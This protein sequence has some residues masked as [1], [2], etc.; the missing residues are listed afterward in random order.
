MI[1]ISKP[2]FGIEEENAVLEVLRSG[3]IV[4]GKKVEELEEKFA[5]V[6]GTKYAVAV[7]SGTAALQISLSAAGIKQGDEIITTPFSFIA[8]ANSCL[9]V[10]ATPVF[11]D[12]NPQTFNINPDLVEAAI[13]KKTRA[14]L[15]VHLFGLPAE[16]KKIQR[17]AKKHRLIIIEDAC[18]AHGASIAGKKVG[19]FGL[20][21]CFS[22]YATKNIAA[23]EGGIITTNNKLFADKC[24][25]LRSHGSKVKY[26]HDILGYN[27]RMTDIEAAIALEQ[28]KKLESNNRKRAD[29]AGFYNDNLHVPGIVQPKHPRGISHVFHQY[30]I[31]ITRACPFTRENLTEELQKNAIGF[32]I[33]YP[34]SIPKQK[35]YQ[36]IGIGKRYKNTL[37]VTERVCKEVISLP[38]HPL[39]TEDDLKKIVEVINH[40]GEKRDL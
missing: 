17:I 39:L 23:G 15:P 29:N 34:L 13:T 19:S 20:A 26:Y 12:I 4:Q 11:V 8:T 38:V 31:Q 5:H 33:F 10:G 3:F 7:S 32:G 40:L 2:D 36:K 14:I 35:L 6:I 30:T 22:F 16:M 27:L 37:P 21:G 28:L 25:L 18:Q 9:Y 24:R 1:S